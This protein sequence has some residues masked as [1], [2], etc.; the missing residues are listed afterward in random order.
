[1]RADLLHVVA[2]VANPIRWQ[3]RI[4]LAK[5]FIENMLASGVNLTI[6]ECAYGGRDF[7]LGED[8]RYRHVKVRA[9]GAELVWNKECLWTIGLEHLPPEAEYIC[10]WDA[11]IIRCRNP[12]WAEDT[13]HQ[14][15]HYPVVM[16]WSDCID[17]GPNGELLETHTALFKLFREGR[18]IV[19]GP[20]VGQVAY[21]FGH[22]GYGVAFTRRALDDLGGL[23]VTAPLGSADHHMGMALLHRVDDSIPR[24]M[25][26]AYKAPMRA[27]QARAQR[28]IRKAVSFVPNVIEHGFHGTKVSRGYIPRWDILI[29]HHFDPVWDLR[30]NSY[31]VVQLAGNKAELRHAVDLYFRQRNEDVN[32]V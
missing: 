13:V 32:S 16:P 31:G 22:P 26:P 28:Y 25:T 7:E 10:F 20:N 2:C 23:I 24:A 12:N 5:Q 9:N 14:L 8:P 15:Q 3:S 1:M 6:V 29:R 17:L 11:D 4:S 18:P 30:W 27:W 19:Q 21:K